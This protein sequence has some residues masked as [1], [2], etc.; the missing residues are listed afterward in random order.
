M[1]KIVL[2]IIV[3]IAFACTSNTDLV[4]SK[5]E[6]RSNDKMNYAA[7]TID[8]NDIKKDCGV[9]VNVEK[10]S[11]ALGQVVRQKLIQQGIT[12]L[13]EIQFITSFSKAKNNSDVNIQLVNQKLNEIR[14]A[15]G[16][17][18]D[19]QRELSRYFGMYYAVTEA[20]GELLINM[21]LVLFA[22]GFKD[23]VKGIN[24]IGINCDSAFVSVQNTYGECAGKRF[25][26]ENKKRKEITV[27]ASGLQY[28][29]SEKLEGELPNENSKVTVHY[30]GTLVSGEEFDSSYKRGEPVSFGLQQ[31][32]AGW[33]EG[34]QLMTK[35]S[36][37]KFYIPYELGYGERPAAGGKIPG[38][39]TL[40]FEVELIDF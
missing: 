33:T 12:D 9:D 14:Q 4:E 32:I 26:E 36:K 22:N 20:S 28:E 23:K 3:L 2:A 30:K 11:Y 18:P 38:F 35:G 7:S 21:N 1:K 15:Q 24:T 6:D 10:V 19:S 25:L 5:R 39:S 29:V 8:L 31:V 16:K 40:I 27:T 13:N 17:Y 34:L 37:Y